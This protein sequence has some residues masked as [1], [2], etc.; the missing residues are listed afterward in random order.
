MSMYCRAQPFRGCLNDCCHF[1]TSAYV[2]QCFLSFF[3]A[4]S[5]CIALVESCQ[6]VLTLFLSVSVLHDCNCLQSFFWIPY[7]LYLEQFDV[8]GVA[9]M[10]P[11]FLHSTPCIASGCF[12]FGVPLMKNSALHLKELLVLE[13]ALNFFWS[14]SSLVGKAFSCV[15]QLQEAF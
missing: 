6:W 8:L 4:F 11:S 10:P 15:W 5:S 7:F 3:F 12:F 14:C 9:Y 13:F 2:L 1:R